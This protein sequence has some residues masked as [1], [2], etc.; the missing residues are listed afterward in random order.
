MLMTPKIYISSSQL[1]PKLHIFIQLLQHLFLHV[2]QISQSSLKLGHWSPLHQTSQSSSSQW[3]MAMHSSKYSGQKPQGSFFIASYLQ[4][5]SKSISKCQ[6]YLQSIFIFQPLLL[7]L[8]KPP[9]SLTWINV[10]YNQFP[11]F[12]PCSPSVY[13]KQGSQ[14]GSIKNINQMSFLCS[15]L[16]ND[17]PPKN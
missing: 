9:C 5:I 1:S 6:F 7:L 17:F 4:P 8:S 13:Y 2:Q 16:S 12:H 14:S 3:G 11:C 10:S 15:K